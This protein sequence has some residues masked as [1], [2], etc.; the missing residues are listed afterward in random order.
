MSALETLARVARREAE[1]IERQLAAVEARRANILA[2]IETH[3][4][5]VR[6]EQE[7]AQ[8]SVDAAL[9][10]G[11]FAQAAI[12]Q[13]RVMINEDHVLAAEA[14]ALRDALR[15]AFIELKKVETLIENEAER[16]ARAAA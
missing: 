15:D 14:G 13:R 5:I 7:R 12:T 1:A 2:R 6:D 9:A 11:A 10:Y 16:A 8:G 3:D 4:R